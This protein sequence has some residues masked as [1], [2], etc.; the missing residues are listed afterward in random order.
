MPIE[1]RIP[2]LD[3]G[4]IVVEREERRHHRLIELLAERLTICVVSKSVCL[5]PMTNDLV[6]EHACCSSFEDR[7][8]REWLGKRSFAERLEA[9]NDLGDRCVQRRV[10]RQSFG[11]PRLERLEASEVHAVG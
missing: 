2:H 7:R 10:V 6:K 9:A 8:T 5:E 1:L 11:R 4:R 3:E